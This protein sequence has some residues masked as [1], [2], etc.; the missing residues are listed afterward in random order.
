MDYEFTRVDNARLRDLLGIFKSAF[1]RAPDIGD[2]EAKH[3]TGFAG[4]RDMGFIAYAPDGE[5]NC[6]EWRHDGPQGARRPRPV[7]PAREDYLPASEPGWDRR[8]LRLSVRQFI[9]RLRTQ[10]GLATPCQHSAVRFL[11]ADNPRL[12]ALL[13]LEPN[14][15]NHAGLATPSVARLPP[16]TVLRG[17][18][19]AN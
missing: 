1:G 19:D 12:G 17:P 15:G 9:S 13:A 14:E 5:P 8:S 4:A 3:D 10:A 16:W 18:V 7:H 11:C 6:S 2:L